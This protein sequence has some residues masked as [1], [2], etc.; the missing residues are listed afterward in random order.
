MSVSFQIPFSKYEN[1]LC[2]FTMLVKMVFIAITETCDHCGHY[3]CLVKIS[4]KH[5]TLSF[6][7]IFSCETKINS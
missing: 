1:D 3:E 4:N 2:L 6:E 5:F 7:Q